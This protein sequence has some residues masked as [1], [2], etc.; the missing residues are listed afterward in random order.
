MSKS[1]KE[2]MSKQQQQQVKY[3]QAEQ[4]DN[5]NDEQIPID[6]EEEYDNSAPFPIPMHSTTLDR[7]SLFESGLNQT[8]KDHWKI[9]KDKTDNS[10]NMTNQNTNNNSHEITWPNIYKAIKSTPRH[11]MRFL[12][13]NRDDD[14]NRAI[15][16]GAS[17]SSTANART[18]RFSSSNQVDKTVPLT[19][20]NTLSNWNERT[21]K[22]LN[23]NLIF[24]GKI[25]SKAFESYRDNL[26]ENCANKTSL[27]YYSKITGESHVDAG[28]PISIA[29]LAVNGLKKVIKKPKKPSSD[30]EKPSPEKDFEMPVLKSR[31]IAPDAGQ[32]RP[33]NRAYFPEDAEQPR[34]DDEEENLPG[35]CDAFTHAFGTKRIFGIGFCGR[36]CDNTLDPD[37][38]NEF[39]E[40]IES[41]KQYR[42]YFTYWVTFVQILIC[43]IS[44]FA[45]G[46]APFG[47]SYQVKRGLATNIQLEKELISYPI[48]QNFWIGPAFV[49]LYAFFQ[50]LTFLSFDLE[51][52]FADGLDTFRCQICSVHEK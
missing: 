11:A 6:E 5:N 26:D 12:G 36:L 51:F 9:V 17:T 50:T 2:T 25:K 4:N 42:P 29:N 24:G 8:K 10:A 13:V 45:Y 40:L 47:L 46:L 18:S 49:N 19:I 27:F 23:N 21:F 48:K 32:D 15:S 16:S 3:E 31:L 39:Q 38:K 44:I 34:T 1:N 41:V 33:D 20:N 14:V 22:V 52:F 35:P 43:F 30:E 7:T 37:K 28:P